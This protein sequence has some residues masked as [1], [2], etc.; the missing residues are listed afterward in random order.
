MRILIA[1]DRNW[2]NVKVIRKVIDELYI[3]YGRFTLIHGAA[4]G[5]DSI[6]AFICKNI[7]KLDVEDYPA[8]WDKFGRVAGRLRNKR[9]LAEGRPDLGVVFHNNL[10]ESKGTG[11]MYEIL[12]LANIPRVWY[13]ESGKQSDER[14]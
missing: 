13:T 5:V 4:K 12:G 7:Y 3:T 11:H 1:G 8:N 9:M 10:A 14:M 2:T 6:A